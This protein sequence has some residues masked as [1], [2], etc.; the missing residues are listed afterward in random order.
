MGF[1]QDLFIVCM[2]NDPTNRWGTISTM[3]FKTE[4]TRRI[5][6]VSQSKKEGLSFLRVNARTGVEKEVV[7]TFPIVWPQELL[8]AHQCEQGQD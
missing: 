7:R 1:S 2:Y 5:W 3:A 8:G 4:Q 6:T